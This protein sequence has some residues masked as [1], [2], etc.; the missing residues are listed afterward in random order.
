MK[1]IISFLF[2]HDRIEN[3]NRFEKNVCVQ[4]KVN[5][6][7]LD[8]VKDRPAEPY[9]VDVSQSISESVPSFFFFLFFFSFLFAYISGYQQRHLLTLTV[10]IGLKIKFSKLTNKIITC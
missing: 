9:F 6:S 4:I 1:L 2:R 3:H 7:W 8:F 10:K 5:L